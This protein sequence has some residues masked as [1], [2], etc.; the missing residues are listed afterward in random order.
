MDGITRKRVFEPFFTTKDVGQGTGLGL[1]TVYG[2]VKQH[3]GWTE[4]ESAV[5]Q[6]TTF[7]VFLPVATTTAPPSAPHPPESIPRAGTETILLVEDEPS[8]RRLVGLCLKRNG[9]RVFEATNGREAL[10]LWRQHSQQIDLLF[11]D[12]VMPEGM[13]GLE[14]AKRLREDKSGLKVI[15]SSGYSLEMSSQGA[16]TGQKT[17]FLAKPYEMPSLTATVRRC[18]DEP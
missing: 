1:A 14:L 2:I 4:V 10:A 12:M 16:P 17:A 13:T 11:T 3:Q 6:G 18:L 5:G 9:Y 7:W 8:V 15:V